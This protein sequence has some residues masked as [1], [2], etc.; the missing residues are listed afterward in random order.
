MRKIAKAAGIPIV[1][2]TETAPAGE[3]YQSWM[4]NELSAVERALSKEAP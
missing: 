3:N 4:M 1:G 2:A